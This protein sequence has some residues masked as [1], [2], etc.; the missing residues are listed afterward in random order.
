MSKST[1][2][3][4]TIVVQKLLDESHFNQDLF[5]KEQLKEVREVLKVFDERADMTIHVKHVA[6]AMRA[7][8]R[9]PSKEYSEE[10]VNTYGPFRNGYVT[11]IE[12]LTLLS[13]Q[14]WGM[15]GSE[16]ELRVIFRVLLDIKGSGWLRYNEM[17]YLLQ[18]VGNVLTEEEVNKIFEI[19]HPDPDGN[20]QYSGMIHTLLE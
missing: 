18:R 12:F 13:R 10:I 19:H 17:R 4:E 14:P 7:L 6:L 15:E 1:K 9:L 11:F 8:G 5:T 3:S 2:S 16:G 20:I